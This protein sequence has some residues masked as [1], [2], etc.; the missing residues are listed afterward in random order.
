[1]AQLAIKGHPTRGKEVI[2]I[3]EMLGGKISHECGYED[4]FDTNY[5]Y[6]I[7]TNENYFIDGLLI[8]D[9]NLTK[10]S[11]LTLE[12]FLEK[13]PYK[14]GDRVLLKGVVKTIKQVCWNNTE[15]EVIYKLETNIRGFSEEYYVYHY[16]L[17][18]YKEE[19]I[20]L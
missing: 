17:K 16:D 1:M 5:V 8:G 18:P 6:F 15:N 20:K 19:T 12:E 14:V 10:F 4:G 9:K 2:E 7:D 13:F 11:I 3:L